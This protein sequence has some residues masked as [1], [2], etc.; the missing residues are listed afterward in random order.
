MPKKLTKRSD[1]MTMT[2]QVVAQAPRKPDGTLTTHTNN[3]T[4]IMQVFF[5]HDSKETFEEKLLR[6]V[7]AEE[8]MTN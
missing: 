5:N 4:M 3:Q 8:M 1:L 6:V 2:N 7:L